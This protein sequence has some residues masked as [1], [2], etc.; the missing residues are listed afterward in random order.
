VALV[1]VGT[2][3]I[4]ATPIAPAA[5]ENGRVAG[6]LSILSDSPLGPSASVLTAN[7]RLTIDG[8]EDEANLF[9][10]ATGDKV[11]VAVTNG[12]AAQAPLPAAPGSGTTLT[13]ATA[14]ATLVPGS[15]MV[16]EEAP[17]VPLADPVMHDLT[18]VRAVWPGPELFEAPTFDTLNKAAKES[19]D[20]WRAATDGKID[21]QVTEQFDSVALSK[22]PCIDLYAAYDEVR[23][24]TGWQEGAGKHLVI[25]IPEC[26]HIDGVNTDG[27]GSVGATPASGGFIILNGDKSLNPGVDGDISQTLAHELGHNMSLNHSNQAICSEKDATLITAPAQDCRGAEYGGVY[28]VMGGWE[29]G[30][31][32]ALGGHHSFLMGLTS[33]DTLVDVVATAPQQTITLVPT[34][35]QTSGVKFARIT[36]TR[37]NTYYLEYRTPV[38]LDATLLD[39]ATPNHLLSGVMVT[40]VF[41]EAPGTPFGS[42]G[43][44]V[45]PRA[46]YLLD[47]DPFHNPYAVASNGQFD[48]DAG[49]TLGTPIALGDVSVKLTAATADAAAVQIDFPPSRPAATIPGKPLAVSAVKVGNTSVQVAWK[50]PLA[51]GGSYIT[52]YLVRTDK[53]PQTCTAVTEFS[54]RLDGL[55]LGTFHRFTV[56]ATSGIGTSAPSDPSAPLPVGPVPTTSPTPAPT[57]TPTPTPTRPVVTPAPTTSTKPTP[58]PTA[59][60][61]AST[62]NI[63]PAPNSNTNTVRV[64]TTADP[65]STTSGSTSGTVDPFAS[66]TDPYASSYTDP[67]GSATSSTTS[68]YGAVDPYTT[69]ASTTT[70]TTTLA[71]TG[72]EGVPMLVSAGVGSLVLGALLILL[73]RPRSQRQ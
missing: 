47:A 3:L 11:S 60:K 27:W 44:T 45:E 67:Y 53:G 18:L 70:G 4:A 14:D 28:S 20:Y 35:G 51:T 5:A 2:L 8:L 9:G 49:L 17:M 71:T 10:L 33:S 62:A 1:A 69:G 43:I 46:V 16:L 66:T 65:F 55:E 52:S 58:T 41:A 39:P 7:G 59:P 48:G 31:Q 6:T 37:G 34:A 57:P 21:F 38:G 64:A 15:L 32:P 68:N 29:P 25:A 36:D 30:M 26:V 56:T 42:G 22:P 13:P 40:K 73:T 50:A 54:C 12:A 24:R 61:P 23:L 72:G 19:A 63:A